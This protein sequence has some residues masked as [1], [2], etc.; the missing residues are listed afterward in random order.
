MQLALVEVL[1][2]D[3]HPGHSRGSF[4][5]VRAEGD[6]CVAFLRNHSTLLLSYSAV[7][8]NNVRPQQKPLRSPFNSPGLVPILAPSDTLT[9]T[10]TLALTLTLTQVST[11]PGVRVCTSSVGV[12]IVW[13]SCLTRT[14]LC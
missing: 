4:H 5:V 1:G 7:A 3:G 8:Q 6:V 12:P 2:C 10:L 14:T 11:A 13:R 9:L